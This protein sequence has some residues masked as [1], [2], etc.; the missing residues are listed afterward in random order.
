M[1]E[2]AG[3]ISTSVD[4]RDF[5][6]FKCAFESGGVG[7]IAAEINGVVVGFVAI[8]ES[9]DGGG[10]GLEKLVEF[11]GE[12]SDFFNV[13]SEEGGLDAFSLS[14]SEAEHNHGDSLRGEGFSGGDGDF[15]A[16]VDVGAAINFASDGGTNGVDDTDGFNALSFEV[17]EA[18]ESVGGF[19]GLRDDESDR[20][21][22]DVG[23]AIA[24][25][26]SHNG[27]DGEVG[28]EP[29]NVVASKH[30]GVISGATTNDDEVFDVFEFT[31][32]EVGAA[33]VDEFVF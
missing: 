31:V 8:G 33:K 25:F 6:E 16:D 2:F 24:V 14:D 10:S 27:F 18:S 20:M 22:G 15:W 11:F 30:T 21:V 28:R 7:D 5:F 17:A 1:F 13:G 19:A 32:G 26:G 29:F 9:L 4:V 23:M 3:R 12:G